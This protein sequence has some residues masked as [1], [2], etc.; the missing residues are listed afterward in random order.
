MKKDFKPMLAGKAPEMDVLIHP[1]KFT[2]PR[3]VSPKLDGIRAVI[4]DGQV[5]SR[6]L[7]P[8]P[9]PTVQEFFGRADFNGFDGELIVGSPTAPDACR[10]S[11]KVTRHEALSREDADQLVLHVFDDFTRDASPFESRFM[12]LSKRIRKASKHLKIVPHE[13]VINHHGLD[14]YEDLWLG[15]GY[16]G[17]MMRDPHAPYKFGRST[18]KEAGLLKV[19]RFE[20]NE[21]VV[22]GYKELQHNEN[23]ERTGGLA[24]RRSSKKAGKVGGGT[25]GALCVRRGDGVEFDVG[26]GFDEAERAAL[27]AIRDTLLGKHLKYRFFAGGSKSRPRFPTY[28]GFRDS[29]DL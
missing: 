20:D 4:I 8:F 7:I 15:E 2:W 6:N 29:I 17:L 19:K 14:V 11:M 24:Q 23:T 16:E 12:G 25:L 27:W 10:N 28:L 9:C 5:L 26:T 22:I 18:T 3:L 21:A 13:R 1:H